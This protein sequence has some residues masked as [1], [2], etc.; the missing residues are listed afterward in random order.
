MNVTPTPVT[1][2]VLVMGVLSVTVEGGVHPDMV[3][4]NGPPPDAAPAIV[5]LPPMS[6]VVNGCEV[7]H[8]NVESP[9]GDT[10]PSE[11]VVVNATVAP[12]TVVLHPVVKMTVVELTNVA[13]VV[14][15]FA[16]LG[17]APF[18]VMD[19]PTSAAV[20][21]TEVPHVSLAGF[22]IA[23]SDST[24]VMLVLQPVV[25]VTC[26]ALT[27]AEIVVMSGAPEEPAPFTW[28]FLPASAVVNG[29]DTMHVNVVLAPVDIIAS[30]MT[31]P[32]ITGPG[33]LIVTSVS[34][35][36]RACARGRA[37]F[38]RV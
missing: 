5:M 36:T 19:A 15:R 24:V 22:V 23:P 3:V 17:P 27:Y 11:T 31:L 14:T 35:A 6:A 34:E 37:T 29:V 2:A 10:T 4:V 18:T 33:L 8:V 1:P 26:D 21:G 12:L 16:P 38:E 25:R 32:S 9:D 20:K 28:M 7:A 30:V 13:I